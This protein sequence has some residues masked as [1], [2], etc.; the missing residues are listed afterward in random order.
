MTIAELNTKVQIQPYTVEQ[1]EDGD[2]VT[3]DGT[4]YNKW[5]KVEQNNGNLL[6]SNGMINFNEAYQ[7]TMRYEVSRPT[8]VTHLVNYKGKTMKIYNVQKQFEGCIWY[9]VVTC[10]T[11]N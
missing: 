3:T 6:A 11:Q 4:A 9:E 10:Y 7:I 8:Q 2:I 5:A 1:N